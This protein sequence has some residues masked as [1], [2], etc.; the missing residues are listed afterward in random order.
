MSHTT[1]R[2]RTPGLVAAAGLALLAPPAARGGPT[3]RPPVP[4]QGE[5]V[6]R[7]DPELATVPCAPDLRLVWASASA[8]ALRLSLGAEAEVREY[9]RNFLIPSIEVPALVFALNWVNRLAG[10]EW[11]VVD[12]FN[13]FWDHLFHGPWVYDTDDIQTNFSLHPYNGS[14]YFN[15]A[16]SSGLDFYWSFG[17]AFL[18]SLLWELGA[19]VE[20]PSKNDQVMTP[21]GGAFIGE[22][23]YRSFALILTGGGSSPGFWREAGAFVVSPAAGFNRLLFGDRYRTPVWD[24]RPSV[25]LRLGAGGGVARNHDPSGGR[26]DG[27]YFLVNFQME[28]G[29]PA[30]PSFRVRR[31]FDSFMLRFAV[32]GA[33]P[34]G[35]GGTTQAHG[36]IAGWR[37]DAGP[38]S[39]IWGIAGNYD[40]VNAGVYRIGSAALGLDATGEFALSDT[41]SL[42][43]SLSLLAV[44]MG[45]AGATAQ[46]E[47]GRDYHVG[48]G[49]QANLDLRLNV[50]T[51]AMLEL[52]SREFFIGPA[53][54]PGWEDITWG[55]LGAYLRLGGPHAVALIVMSS[56]RTAR[57]TDVPD[58][59]QNASVLS[60]NYVW[61]SDRWFGA[62][63]REPASAD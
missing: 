46:P 52:S 16:R 48:Q 47:G 18:G 36:T 8:P 61:L 44:L 63:R 39:G 58:V 25:F 4:G 53:A 3:P 28:Y 14:L 60:L 10:N 22:A 51:T 59:K 41:V 42:R 62:A 1:S 56:R 29:Q 11:A 32:G 13:T 40:F 21:V 33:G 6:L 43:T 55:T 2:I 27:G 7:L 57:Y 26:R 19:E 17:Y 24:E 37:L 23:L 12:G 20:S 49:G 35:P 38:F 5:Y 54:F 31:P 9:Q 45:A 50:G 15:M 30:D 34:I